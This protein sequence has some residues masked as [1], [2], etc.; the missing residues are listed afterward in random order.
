[1]DILQQE[2]LKYE[3]IERERKFP[4]TI[5]FLKEN[6]IIESIVCNNRGEFR[7]NWNIYINQYFTWVDDKEFDIH[8][9]LRRF[10]TFI[11]GNNLDLRIKEE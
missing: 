3:K 10:A 4:V 6:T 7:K 5:E 1:M 9:S 8:C 2:V 11:F